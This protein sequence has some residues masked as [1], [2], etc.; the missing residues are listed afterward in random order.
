MRLLVSSSPWALPRFVPNVFRELAGQGA[1]LLFASEDDRDPVPAGLAQH[2]HVGRA[3]LSRGRHAGA[4][5]VTLFRRLSDLVRF[6]DPEL[7]DAHWPRRRTALRVLVR[8]GHPDAESLADRLAAL[9]LPGE[10]HSSLAGSLGDIERLL[11][12]DPAMVGAMAALEVDAVL[13]VSRCSLGGAERDVIKAARHLGLP[14]I[15]L[16]WSWDNLSSKALLTE[17]PDHLLVW[18]DWQV[19]EAVRLHGLPAERVHPLGAPNFDDF[20]DRLASL[21]DRG[22]PPAGAPRTIL[23]LG[24]SK[25][26]SREEPVLFERWLAAVRSAD[27]P[28]VRRARVVVRPY[29]GVGAWSRWRPGPTDDL[30]VERSPKTDTAGLARLL[31]AADAVVA[32]NTSAEIEAAIAGRPVVTFRGGPQ[33]PGQEGS[34]HFEYLLE[35]Q[36]GFVI[37]SPSLDAHVRNLARVLR[38]DHDREGMRRFVERFVRPLGIDRPVAPI[39]ASTLLRLAAE[40]QPAAVAT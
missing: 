31:A 20:F 29:P 13:L 34:V 7:T 35:R 1:H 22:P 36:G 30:A 17:H 33:A 19:A 23:Y 26:I 24:S 37:D 4:E 12:P 28:L 5:A 25:N 9:S 11:P 16:V 14:T 40:Q 10:V 6:L 38:G 32:L 39:V 2:P 27:E 21:P 8:A 15:M 3:S 18:N